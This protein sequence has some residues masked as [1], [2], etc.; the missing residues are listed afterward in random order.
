MIRR[1]LLLPASL[2]SCTALAQSPAQPQANPPAMRFEWV[3]EGPADA[4]A[5]H[6]REWISA[7]GNINPNTP[8][9]FV[10]FMQARDVRGATVVLESEGGALG[11][12]IGLGR[13]FRRFAMATMVG[14]TV[15]LA[16]GGERATLSPAALCASACTFALL[17]GARRH[18]P[19]EA[20]VLV[21]QVWPF[22][23]REDAV[24]AS[25]NAQDLVV[26]QREL[27]VLAKYIVDMGADI[28][29]FEIAER[30]PPWEN[31]RPLSADD[32]RRLRVSTVDDPF[33]AVPA[34]VDAT[35]TARVAPARPLDVIDRAWIVEDSDGQRSF[36]RRHPLTIEGE[37]IGTFELAFRCGKDGQVTVAYNENRH[38]REGLNDRLS[39]VAVGSGKE[40]VLLKV[41]SSAT[42][43]GGGE[44]RSTAR[45]PVP[46][47]L[48][49]A[50]VE[51][52]GR[53]LMVATQTMSN[54]RTVIH[55]GNNGFAENFRSTI[56]ECKK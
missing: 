39:G 51:T 44:L 50:L 11:G 49:G 6:C 53:A 22:L 29:L 28:E 15:K 46:P 18:V 31:P 12:S 35:A 48:L 25:Y 43:V 37:Q 38:L 10:E 32:V 20:R 56:G 1:V 14:H 40:R 19:V 16:G 2:L 55:P 3:R 5:D 4:C 7:H 30:I 17:G 13:L 33:A 54:T 26:V 23:K 41:E 27:G 42:D 36:S 45:S 21:H 47:A 9:I 34:S 8:R 24:G 52:G